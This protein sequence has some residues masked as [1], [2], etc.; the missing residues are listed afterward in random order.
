MNLR[1]LSRIRRQRSEIV[2]G[3]VG[4]VVGGDDVVVARVVLD[5]VVAGIVL[6]VL[7]VLEVLDVVDDVVDVVV[8]VS[9]GV[10]SGCQLGSL[11]MK[12]APVSG[13]ETLSPS[14]STVKMSGPLGAPKEL[15]EN[16]ILVPSGDHA[17]RTELA[18]TCSCSVPSAFILHTE[19]PLP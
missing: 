16:T 12:G 7:D 14:G 15:E 17:G 6:D 3:V 19:L 9:G 8:V 11:S 5:V 18:T 10:V 13:A 2:V 1:W 4:A